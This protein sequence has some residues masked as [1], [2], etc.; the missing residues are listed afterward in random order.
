MTYN[1]KWKKKLIHQQ[2]FDLL[3]LLLYLL[4]RIQQELCIQIQFFR[5]QIRKITLKSSQKNDKS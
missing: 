5:F 1:F 3:D 2:I 4:Q